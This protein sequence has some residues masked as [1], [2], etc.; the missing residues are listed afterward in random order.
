MALK[1]GIS[2]KDLYEDGIKQAQNLEIDIRKEE[3]LHI[4][5]EEY[6]KI[7]TENSEYEGK[8][9]I[10]A[11]GNKKLRP[12]IKGVLDF[13]GRGISYCAICDGFFY[14][15]K[16]V[17]VIGNGKFANSEAEDLKNIVN[18]VK[19]LTDNKEME[20]ST[21]FEVIKTKIK[22]IQGDTK[23]RTVEFEDGTT[24]AVDGVFIAIGEAGG[25]DFAKKIGVLTAND[26]IIVDENMR[27]K[28]KRIIFLWKFYRRITTSL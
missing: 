13:E 20:T 8:T 9:L 26:N 17:V 19:I 24:L 4:E 5:K 10:L 21:E 15:K 11:T 23:V 28:C 12:N 7:K 18:N 25:A 16:N 3:V 1:N 22:E 14:R 2:G 27:N 6:F